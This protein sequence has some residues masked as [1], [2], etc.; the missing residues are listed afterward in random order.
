MHATLLDSC[1]TWMPMII[2]IQEHYMDDTI[3]GDAS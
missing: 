1:A 2:P 3:T